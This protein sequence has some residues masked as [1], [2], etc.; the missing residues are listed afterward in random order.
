[1]NRVAG[2]KSVALGT[3]QGCRCDAAT[4]EG[5]PSADDRFRPRLHRHDH[6]HNVSLGLVSLHNVFQCERHSQLRAGDLGPVAAGKT[7]AAAPDLGSSEW[8]SC[9]VTSPPTTEQDLWLMLIVQQRWQAR[10][11]V[12]R[13]SIVRFWSMT[14][15]VCRGPRLVSC[16]RLEIVHCVVV[17]CVSPELALTVCTGRA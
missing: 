13:V 14:T 4:R 10:V 5:G 12:F 15:C 17:R 11:R 8:H 3:F 6:L 9:L 7:K 2:T 1:M 16:S